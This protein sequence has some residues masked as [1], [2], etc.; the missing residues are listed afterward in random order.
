[1]KNL[2]SEELERY[3]TL[4][5]YNTKFTLTEN[6]EIISE[7]IILNEQ[8]GAA[9]RTA[10]DAL[11][12]L[13]VT[14]K[15]FTSMEAGLLTKLLQ[16]DDAAFAAK[17]KTAMKTDIKA[18]QSAMVTA[19]ELSKIQVIRDIARLKPTTSQQMD[20]IIKAVKAENNL[21]YSTLRA[22][23]KTRV[24]KGVT[25][26]GKNNKQNAANLGNTPTGKS[27]IAKIKAGMSWPTL[28]KV[29]AGVATVGVLWWLFT[30]NSDDPQ[31][32]QPPEPPEPPQPPPPRPDSK[33]KT[34]PD[35][36]PIEMYC[37]NETVRKVQGC[38]SIKTDGAFGPGTQTALVAKGLPGTEITQNT[39]DVACGSNVVEP[40]VDPN[41]DLI[42]GEDPM[43]I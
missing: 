11:A 15:R 21:A 20:D 16:I 19:R 27:L 36:F 12:T 38:L 41:V 18:G 30:S 10:E 34:C 14:F 31:P 1:M 9:F 37:K 8:P 2:L 17:L 26:T 5:N 40:V 29:G 23:T 28:L 24:T 25:G 22:N 3:R 4:S 42:D 33:Y 43:N 13:G 32:P 7:N 35:T 6:T 39:V